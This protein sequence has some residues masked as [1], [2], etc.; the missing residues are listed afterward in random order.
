MYCGNGWNE[1]VNLEAMAD[2]QRNDEEAEAGEVEAKRTEFMRLK[3]ETLPTQMDRNAELVH[4]ALHTLKR[5]VA[6]TTPRR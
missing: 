1:C 5:V 3:L 6:P 2:Q 4:P